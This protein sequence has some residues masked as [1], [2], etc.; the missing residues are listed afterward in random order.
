MMKRRD[1]FRLIPLSLAGFGSIV[2]ETEAFDFNLLPKPGDPNVP[3]SVQYIQNVTDM[4]LDIRRT[5][6]EKIL[7]S[8]YAIARTI[9][10]GRTCWAYCDQGH[11]YNSD[12]F[13]DRNGEPEIVTAGYDPEKARDGDLLLVQQIP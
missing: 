12:I 4:L 7:E 1:T 3:L 6:S 8:A 2:R 11:A 9:K 13:P 5:Q 10:K